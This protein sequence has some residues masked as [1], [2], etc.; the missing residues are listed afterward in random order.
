V[1]VLD[2]SVA[3][4]DALARRGP[5]PLT[6]LVDATS[7]ARPTAHRLAVALEAHGLV[8]RDS[9]GRFRLGARLGGW[10]R[11]ALATGG[12]ADAAGPVL[13]GLRDRTAES[14]Q[15]FVRDGDRRVCVAA[16]EPQSGLRDTVPVGA[17]L[18]LD[19]GSGG[20]VLL[21]WSDDA[22]SEPSSELDRVRARGWAESVAER[23]AGVA[24][25]SAP[26][27]DAD[28]VVRAAI[29]VSG[30]ADRLGR[31][32]GRRFAKAV[33]AAAHDLE[34]RAGWR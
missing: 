32:P 16:A 19:R 15:L 14:A 22:R 17:S 27:F 8:G 33:V 4:L 30:P 18:P 31:A 20:K 11:A 13:A 6:D 21:A 1:G 3:I 12:L 24:S 5:L 28:G 29:S 34:R 9:A 25:V 2:K 10:G 23:E 26:V 7:I